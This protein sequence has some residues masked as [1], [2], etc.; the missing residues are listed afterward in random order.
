MFKRLLLAA[1]GS[2]NSYRAAEEVVKLA[3]ISANAIVEVVYI[4]DY[5]KAAREVL[6]SESSEALELERKKKLLPIE[7]LFKSNNIKYQITVLHGEPGPMIVEYANKITC[8]MVIIGSR[9]LNKLQEM[10]L[11]SV[12]HK[13]AKRATEIGRAHV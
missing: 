8:D 1:D 2:E 11:G 13:V 7:T 4:I 12:S 5:S 6:H 10:V 9:G 3:S